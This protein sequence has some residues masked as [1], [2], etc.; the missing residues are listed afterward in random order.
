MIF[1]LILLRLI[2]EHKP[3][4]FVHENVPGFPSQMITETLG[5]LYNLDECILSPDCFPVERRR[6]YTIGRLKTTVQILD[7]IH[8]VGICFLLLA[9]FLG[10]EGGRRREET[11]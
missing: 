11:W 4:V 8:Y 7:F 1:L 3:M 9:F 10:G 6:K 5:A 2:I